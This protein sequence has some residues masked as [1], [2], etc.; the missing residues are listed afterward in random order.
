MVKEFNK[1]EEGEALI[2]GELA[3]GD[4]VVTVENN[5]W[6]ETNQDDIE[7]NWEEITKKILEAELNT[8]QDPTEGKVRIEEERAHKILRSSDIIS[9]ST[10][11][12]QEYQAS[13]LLQY[14]VDQGVYQK[15]GSEV[16]VLDELAPGSTTGSNEYNRLN[17]SA[18][19][20]LVLERINNTI[21]IAED[22]EEKIAEM[23]ENDSIGTSVSK[24]PTP[25][26]SK[27]EK[28]LI[29]D[30]SRVTGVSP[31]DIQEKEKQ[32]K[33]TPPG[34][35]QDGQYYAPDQV[36][37]RWEYVKIW[38]KLKAK[39]EASGLGTNAGDGNNIEDAEDVRGRINSQ[40]EQMRQYGIEI[41]EMEPNLRRTAIPTIANL[42]ELQETLEDALQMGGNLFNGAAVGE[43]DTE[44]VVNGVANMASD[45]EFEGVE[46]DDEEV[47]E[48]SD[49]EEVADRETK[50]AVSD[51]SDTNAIFTDEPEN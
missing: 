46:R 35:D 11:Q 3:N 30:L 23:Y 6:T 45:Y 24:I 1:I 38:S 2:R 36:D 17:W 31:Y 51:S 34:K 8:T 4:G 18:F 9:G 12:E 14:L 15:S 40:I 42:P 48:S 21:K 25:E 20:S 32:D 27:S 41:Q 22:Q 10:E 5:N 7:G 13:L 19:L 47:E 26:E 33:W 29:E 37:D 28:E 16:V 39:Q 50:E 49:T 44:E 43:E